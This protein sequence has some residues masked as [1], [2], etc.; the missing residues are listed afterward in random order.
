MS[1]VFETAKAATTAYNEKNWSA[2]KSAFAENGVYDE[3]ATSG[4]VQGVGK[5]LEVWQGWAKAIPDSKA[6][7]VGEYASGDTPSSR[8]SGRA[9]TRA[10]CKRRQAP[11]RRRISESTC[12]RARSS[13]SREGRSRASRSTSTWRPCSRRSA[14][15]RANPA[16]LMG[17][18]Y[19]WPVRVGTRPTE[20][21]PGRS[22]TPCAMPRVDSRTSVNQVAPEGPDLARPE[23]PFHPRRTAWPPPDR[24]AGSLSGAT[25]RTCGHPLELR[26]T[27]VEVSV[28][29]IAD[30]VHGILAVVATRAVKPSAHPPN[31]RSAGNRPARTR[32]AGLLHR[33][34]SSR[35]SH[36]T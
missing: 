33:S 25:C 14:R 34:R 30:S 12:P 3:K 18:R 36:S 15:S 23:F 20:A 22:S 16:S 21:C 29:A 10:H 19:T 35:G 2:L 24:G 4:R 31:T 13:R 26:P 17:R 32:S 27:W 6:T 7:F 9:R 28:V 5:I 8:S 11:S 1:S